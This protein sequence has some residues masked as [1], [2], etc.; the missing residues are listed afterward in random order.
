MSPRITQTGSLN[1]NKKGALETLDNDIKCSKCHVKS[2]FLLDIAEK[3]S[4]L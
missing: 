4:R 1:K 3:I 2:S